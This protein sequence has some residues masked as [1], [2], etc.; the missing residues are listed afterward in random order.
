MPLFKPVQLGATCDLL[1]EPAPARG[2]FI[3]VTG[4]TLRGSITAT[5]MEH[6]ERVDVE[7]LRELCDE[8][9]S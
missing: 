7:R 1:V 3:S 5:M 9:L 2:L 4:T 8:A 6:L